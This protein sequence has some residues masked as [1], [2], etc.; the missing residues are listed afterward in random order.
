[1]SFLDE[2][3]AAFLENVSSRTPAPGGGSVAATTTALAASLAGMAARFSTEHMDEADKLA[4]R[5]DAL[6]DRAASLVQE[7]AA[8]Y[9][10]V[11]E[12]R[13]ASEDVEERRRKIR[14]AFSDAA[15][16]PLSVAEVGAEVAE[17]ASRLAEEGNPNLEGDAL[18][19]TFLAKASVRAAATLAEINLEA[20]EMEDDPRCLR[21]AE[22]TRIV[23]QSETG[24]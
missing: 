21:A 24:C 16:V 6:R 2:T 17:I 18:T 22:L 20:A 12:A 7:D 19:A 4:K 13:R 15:D 23:T 5:A 3:M 8:V 10:R 14:A 9:G 1:M 11:L